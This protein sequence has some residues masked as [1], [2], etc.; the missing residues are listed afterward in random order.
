MRRIGH[1][2][3]TGKTINFKVVRPEA[4]K[5]DSNPLQRREVALDPIG[6]TR[7][8]VESL[9]QKQLLR[10]NALLFHTAPL[11]FEQDALVRG[12]LIDQDEAVCTFHQDIKLTEN[13][14]DLELLLGG[15]PGI[16]L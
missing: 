16:P 13:A 6:V 3:K 11:F 10:R 2:Q 14:D 9:R 15:F 12:M 4:R 1:A 5:S 7:R 8:H